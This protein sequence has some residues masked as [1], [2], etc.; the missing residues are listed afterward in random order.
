MIS[1]GPG[2]DFNIANVHKWTAGTC[3][4]SSASI[5]EGT[6]NTLAAWETAGQVYYAAVNKKTLQV[7]KP[8]SPLRGVERKHP[9]AVANGRG[10]TLFVW[11]EGTGWARGGAVAWQLYD[12]DGKPTAE[13]GRA[14]G[15][16]VW[17]LATAFARPDGDFVIVY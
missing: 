10:E 6:E 3:P 9:V 8:I 4:M 12:Q 13:K 2:A 14:D 17:S 11:T 15:V 7:A 5:T 16:P 1:R